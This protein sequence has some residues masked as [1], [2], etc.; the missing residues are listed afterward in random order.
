MG[1]SHNSLQ[2]RH[3]DAGSCNGCEQELTAV[4]N[5]V[6]DMQQWG[7][8]L[9]ASPRHAD[10]LVVT[11]PVSDTMM[12]PLK[13]VWEAVPGPKRLIALGDCACGC[14]VFQNA[15]ASHGG[16]EQALGQKPDL[17]IHGC[18]PSPQDIVNALKSLNS[19]GPTKDES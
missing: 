15:Y 19:T 3:L 12:R 9:V 14:G 17:V 10:A 6:Y 11:G 8:D 2:V 13:T 4:L 7:I 1:K 5:R 16:L 18:P